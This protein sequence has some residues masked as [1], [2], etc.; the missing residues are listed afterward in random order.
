[1]GAGDPLPEKVLA[2]LVA[3]GE[4]LLN[5][6]RFPIR[7]QRVGGAITS[8]LQVANRQQDR[9]DARIE[10]AEVVSRAGEGAAEERFGFLI[11]LLIDEESSQIVNRHVR[12]RV[13]VAS[14]V[15]FT[16]GDEL[17]TEQSASA[18]RKSSRK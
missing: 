18:S 13:V 1:L 3:A 7:R 5:V 14:A 2:T 9:G 16:L 12:S 4:V 15:G 6:K 8:Q 10:R 17:A 11:V